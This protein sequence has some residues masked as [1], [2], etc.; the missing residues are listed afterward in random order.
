MMFNRLLLVEAKTF[1][2]TLPVYFLGI[3][4]T[5]N[6]LICGFSSSRNHFTMEAPGYNLASKH[7]FGFF[8]D[9]PDEEWEM[10]YRRPALATQHYQFPNN[11][12]HPAN[13]VHW[14]T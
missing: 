8:H 5:V 10:F 12:D 4:F 2:A 14:W 7:S 3:F 1:S 9:I 11:P 6:I 13:D